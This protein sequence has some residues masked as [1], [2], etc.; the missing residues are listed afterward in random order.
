MADIRELAKD[1]QNL[2][3]SFEGRDVLP[4]GDEV[5]VGDTLELGLPIV[6]LKRSVATSPRDFEYM[7][8]HTKEYQEPTG[9]Y[10]CWNCHLP[11]VHKHGKWICP[12]CNAEF[13][14]ANVDSLAPPTEEASYA[15]DLITP[16][17]EW[18]DF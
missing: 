6:W 15:D 10:W 9:E 14:E 7:I 4:D 11:L 5:W 8:V 12:N 17:D 1:W 2:P 18:Y 3:V 13:S 16:N